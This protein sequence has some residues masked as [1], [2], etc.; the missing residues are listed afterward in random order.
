M[1]KTLEQ[2]CNEVRGLQITFLKNGTR[3]EAMVLADSVIGFEIK[4][5]N[6]PDPESFLTCYDI[7]NNLKRY[8]KEEIEQDMINQIQYIHFAAK[9]FAKISFH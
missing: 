8:P 5:L 6:E 2:L 1:E 7:Q 3:Y 4:D 9:F